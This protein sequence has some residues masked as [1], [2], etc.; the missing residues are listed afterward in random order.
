LLNR[1]VWQSQ[2]KKNATTFFPESMPEWP[3]GVERLGGESLI[4]NDIA[5][6]GQEWSRRNARVLI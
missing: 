1:L 5:F 6:R 2:S 4:G 3:P